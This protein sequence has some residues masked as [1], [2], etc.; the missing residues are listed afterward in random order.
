MSDKIINLTDDLL[1]GVGGMR[2][3]HVHPEDKSKLIKTIKKTRKLKREKHEDRY[4]E[5]LTKILPNEDLAW[6]HLPRFYGIC[7][8]NLGRGQIVEAIRDF[9]GNISKLLKFYIKR[10]GLDAY[11]EELNSLKEYFLK[12]HIIFNYDISATNIVL[13]R[14]SQ[15]KQILVLIDAFGDT[16]AIPILNIFPNLVRKKII[17]RWERFEK[18][19]TDI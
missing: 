11:A 3:V 9:D 4:Y 17:R 16:V 1:I 5:K 7:K 19:Y 6:Q 13:K 12:Y 8:T 18:N 2:L 14:V 10:D 15:D